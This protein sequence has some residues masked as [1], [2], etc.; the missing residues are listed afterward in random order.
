MNRGPSYMRALGLRFGIAANLGRC[1]LYSRRCACE[2]THR[3]QR[4]PTDEYARCNRYPWVRA[5]IRGVTLRG[6]GCVRRGGP[7]NRAWLPSQHR[8]HRSIRRAQGGSHPIVLTL[9]AL[10]ENND[11]NMNQGRSYMRALGLRWGI[12]ANFGRCEACFT[13]LRLR[14]NPPMAARTHG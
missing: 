3:W 9:T 10:F 2:G 7:A 14:G 1:D 4:G 5:A 12:A 11:F 8:L 13:A 6:L